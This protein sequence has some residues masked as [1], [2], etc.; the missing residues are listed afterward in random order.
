MEVKETFINCFFPISLRRF[1]SLLSKTFIKRLQVT[2]HVV[3]S[4][5]WSPNYSLH[6]L[7]ICLEATHTWANMGI[8]I[9]L[10]LPHG[11]TKC[12]TCGGWPVNITFLILLS[13]DGIIG[14]YLE[15]MVEG[16]KR[17]SWE[18]QVNGKRESFW[19]CS[20]G[21]LE[22]ERLGFTS[23]F[24]FFCLPHPSASVFSFVKQHLNKSIILIALRIVINV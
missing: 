24:L 5:E 2:M 14:L 3:V 6:T 23:S 4:L 16:E 22:S 18:I 1:V 11:R 10:D 7:P 20:V 17:M 8:K 13:W 12:F 9:Q 19:F 21:I 15:E